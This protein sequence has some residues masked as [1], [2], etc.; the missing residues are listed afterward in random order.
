MKIAD[1]PTSLLLKKR[2]AMLEERAITS[3]QKAEVARLKEKFNELS[4][5]GDS[6]NS[7]F[8]S[9]GWIAYDSMDMRVMRKAI[10][11]SKS[12]G[13][14][15]ANDHL[16]DYYDQ[17]VVRSGIT[18]LWGTEPFRARLHLIKLAYED[19]LCGRYYAC[20]PVL[21]MMIDGVV[22]DAGNNL[23]FFSEKS[24]VTAWNSIAGHETGLL[25]IKA[26]FYASR[27]KTEKNKITLPFRNGIMHGRDLGYANREVAA[28]CWGL[29]FSIRD[30]LAAK[31]DEEYNKKK[32]DIEKAKSAEDIQSEMRAIHH[33]LQ[34]VIEMDSFKRIPLLM[35][36]DIPTTGTP[37]DYPPNSPE[38]AL[39]EFIELWKAKKYG[40]MA[41]YIYLSSYLTKTKMAGRLRQTFTGKQPHHFSLIEV[42]DLSSCKCDIKTIVG[43]AH[44][45]D[46]PIDYTVTFRLLY[47]ELNS[48]ELVVNPAKEGRWKIVDSFST[49]NQIGTSLE[50]LEE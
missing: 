10:E 33:S 44:K 22:S 47:C 4:T 12:K 13:M 21:L 8:S 38:E 40:P 19:F 48:T 14:S 46:F 6:F 34:E 27:G 36:I 42:Q 29:L 39:V 31:R 11:L 43:L 3:D 16:V 7:I 26:I 45:S 23:G 17:D 35:G 18:G 37:D 49:I 2:I 9:K 41:E 50:Y 5:I 20:I 25:A 28:K 1:N 24:D 30:V 32:H 15:Q